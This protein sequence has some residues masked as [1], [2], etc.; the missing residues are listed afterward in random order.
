MRGRRSSPAATLLLRRLL[1]LLLKFLLH[2]LG[3][4]LLQ[5]RRAAAGDLPH[6]DL[7]GKFA[8]L[9]EAR[10]RRG[11]VHEGEALRHREAILAT[12]LHVAHRLG[13]TGID[14]VHDEG[15]RLLAGV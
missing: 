9:G 2:L 15:S 10:W 6:P 11:A 5:H 12:L 3:L 14:A 7:E 1:L 4:H 8:V 13:E